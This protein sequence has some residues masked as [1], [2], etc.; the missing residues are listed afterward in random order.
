M[1]MSSEP[2][3]GDTV[4]RPQPGTADRGQVLTLAGL[5][6]LYVGFG[7]TMGVIQGGF[8]TVMRAAGMSIGSAG[9]LFALYL[10]FGVAFLWSP[11]VDRWKPP[12]LTPRIG[13]IVPLQILAALVVGA[14]AFME[15]APIAL[16]FA[17][18]FLVACA[19]AT[20]DIA[21]DGL[22]VDLVEPSWRPNTAAAKLAALSIGAMIGTGAFVALFQ[23][24]GWRLIFLCLAAGLLLLALPVLSLIPAERALPSR[25]EGAASSGKA[26]LTRILAE[27][28]QRKRLIL[29]TFACCVI[30]PLSGLNRL[31]LV[32][33]GLPV[34]TI[35]WVVGTMGPVA[36]FVTA[37]VSMP[38]MHRMG[39]AGA[40]VAFTALGLLA[41]AAMAA[42]F[43]AVSPAAAI[44]GTILAGAAVSGIYVALTARIL[45]WAVGRQPATDYAVFYGIGRLASTIVMIA[46][47]QF[48]A[49]LGWLL[50]YGLGALA[51]VAVFGLVRGPVSEET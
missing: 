39:L 21:L 48:I 11:L 36:M 46:A 30:F 19:M 24:M 35:G 51:L 18:G 44:T 41:L 26:S 22:A 34:G 15:G 47:A 5:S 7:M 49:H 6:A 1:V 4:A 40:L 16:L 8:P 32:D 17:L 14:V 42:G 38:L 10:P 23:S 45:G 33:L 25:G 3:S 31:M 20:M 13:W 37:L 28:R 50:F 2:A 29:L 9:W 43:R 12:V 27:P